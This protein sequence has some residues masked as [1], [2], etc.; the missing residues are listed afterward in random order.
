MVY[1]YT[2]GDLLI[3]HDL[4]FGHPWFIVLRMVDVWILFSL[5]CSHRHRE[6]LLPHRASVPPR[7]PLG[8]G[9]QQLSLWQRQS[10]LYKGN[11]CSQRCY[12]L[13]V[14]AV[15]QPQKPFVFLT[16][17]FHKTWLVYWLCC[18]GSNVVIIWLKN[19]IGSVKMSL[20][21]LK[22]SFNIAV[23]YKE[24]KLKYQYNRDSTPKAVSTVEDDMLSHPM[25][26]ITYIHCNWNSHI[27][28]IV[29]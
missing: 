29:V 15:E 3:D 20:V 16:M 5:L 7:E 14:V 6:A 27:W 19:V 28:E 26:M 21:Q 12:H 4:A 9:M 1:L 25:I 13:H 22:S 11:C 17:T 24:T 10:Q 2:L 23:I 8:G 18:D